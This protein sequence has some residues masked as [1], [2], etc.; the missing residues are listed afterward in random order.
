MMN[1]ERIRFLIAVGLIVLFGSAGCAPV[2]VSSIPPDARVYTKDKEKFV[3][4]TPVTVN[5]IANDRELVLRKDGYFSQTI[6]LSPI[7]PQNVT[8]ELDRRDRV[9][10]LSDPDGADLYVD[11]VGRV[12]TTPYKVDYSKPYRTFEVKSEGYAT[13]TFTVPEDPEEHLMVELERAE[14]VLLVTKPKNAEIL[15]ADGNI[16]GA[17]PLDVP[18]NEA[19]IYTIRKDGY[20]PSHVNV[21]E[22]TASPVVV[23]LERQPI[24]LIET[25]PEGARIVYRGVMIGQTPFRHLVEEAMDV[26]IKADRCYSKTIT[27]TPESPRYVEI[28][29][30]PM[31]Y[32]TIE[33]D[34]AGA[35]LYRSGGVELVG[36]TPIEVLIEKDTAFEMHKDGYDIKPFTLSP[37][38]K[39]GVTV[40][41]VKSLSAMEKTVL[42][43]STPSGAEVYRPG[44]AELI[45]KT[46]FKQRVRGERTFELHL[47]GYQTKIVTVATDSADSVI[48]ALAKDESAR[49]VTV[50]DPLLN[51]PSSF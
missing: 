8:I 3:G 24:I 22:N 50:S 38:S 26:E 7:D 35:E 25:D 1:K 6:Q 47:A 51:T 44:G 36:N 2:T 41:L 18:G 37:Q 11:G 46:P 30:D 27:L 15:D 12:G 48:F 19:R 9:L 5:L 39:S 43:D 10:I 28:Q 49:N 42:I 40:P 14:T 31:P 23:E 21:D 13:R 16:L 45:G 32:V 4:T 34:P 33:S 17:T 20:Y 29:L